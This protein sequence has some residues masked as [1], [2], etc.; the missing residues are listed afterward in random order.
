MN[1]SCRNI[2]LLSL[3]GVLVILGFTLEVHFANSENGKRLNIMAQA[4]ENGYAVLSFNLSL[5]LQGNFLN[6]YLLIYLWLY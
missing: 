1:E 5:Y 2:M 6:R 3:I 4:S